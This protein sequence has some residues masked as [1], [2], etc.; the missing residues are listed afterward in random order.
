[1][2]WQ[3]LE[4]GNQELA[5]FGRKRFGSRVAY[6]GTIRKDGS[7]R[8]HPVTPF[9][10]E[11]N[12]FIG[13][14]SNSPKGHD[15]R[16]DGRYALHCSMEDDEGGAGEFVITGQAQVTEDSKLRKLAAAGAPYEL[17]ENHVLFLLTVERALSTVYVEGE[18][19]RT[20]WKA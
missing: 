12:L 10:V 5:D 14:S 15:L 11:G 7:P 4:N 19:K 9:I 6:L 8:V 2:T 1:M 13:M 18:T 20:R 16:R 3:A 17:Q